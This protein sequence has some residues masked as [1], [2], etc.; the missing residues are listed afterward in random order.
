MK[1]LEWGPRLVVLMLFFWGNTFRYRNASARRIGWEC[2]V[3]RRKRHYPSQSAK[4]MP[5]HFFEPNP[6]TVLA[7]RYT[8]TSLSLDQTFLLLEELLIWSRAVGGL[9]LR[10]PPRRS[11]VSAIG[12]T[13][14]DSAAFRW[15]F[16]LSTLTSLVATSVS[17][18]DAGVRQMSVNELNVSQ[19]VNVA[20]VPD[21]EDGLLAVLV[22]QE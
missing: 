13:L 14:G 22:Q 12:S 11:F 4:T 20:E 6:P 19:P 2:Q 3:C 7:P 18:R 16:S 9:R 17:E 10:D 1:W 8:T 21:H 5:K 15:R